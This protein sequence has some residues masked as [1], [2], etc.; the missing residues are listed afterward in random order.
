MLLTFPQYSFSL[1]FPGI[2]SQNLIGC[3]WEFRNDAFLD[4]HYSTISVVMY[5]EVGVLKNVL[6]SYCWNR[7]VAFIEDRQSCSFHQT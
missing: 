2:L 1:E 4:T 5:S 3:V 6:P 7:N